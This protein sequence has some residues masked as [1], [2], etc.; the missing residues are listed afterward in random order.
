MLEILDALAEAAWDLLASAYSR[1]EFDLAYFRGLCLLAQVDFATGKPH[2]AQ[3]Q[4]ALG[5]RLAQTRGLLCKEND[6]TS[7]D[8]LSIGW[9][10]L[11]WTLFM[12]DRILTGDNIRSTCIPAF[13]F[14]LFLMR[15]GP[16]HP[17]GVAATKD[18][19]L[20]TSF[21]D[22][23]RAGSL[24]LV[25]CNILLVH[26]WDTTMQDIFQ[27]VPE[28]SVAFWRDGSSR[29]KLHSALLEF[30]MRKQTVAQSHLYSIVGSPQRVVGEPHLR[31]YFGVW[32]FF[33]IM[34]SAINC[35][36]HHPF[37]IFMKTRQHHAQVPLTY[38]QKSY[39]DS[40]I[41][42]DWVIR[43]IV[44]MQEAGI[45][46][47]DPFVGHVVAIAASI[48]LEHTINRHVKIAKVARRKFERARDFVE[49][50]SDKW[51]NM[52]DTLNVL[53]Q[54]SARLQRRQTIR[55]VQDEYNGAIPPNEIQDVAIEP[56]D[57]AL[58][59]KLFDY[60]SLS[61]E[62]KASPEVTPPAAFQDRHD[63][64]NADQAY[65]LVPNNFVTE[66]NT[67]NWPVVENRQAAA[68]QEREP[69]TD[70]FP[71]QLEGFDSAQEFTDDWSLF[72]RPWSVYFSADVV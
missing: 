71:D 27:V 61:S 68:H 34:Y 62:Q 21:E 37:I 53:E 46:L 38:L 70:L 5:L 10:S 30:E 19:T 55:H 56:E 43:H 32:V 49:S 36:L 39:Q 16:R 66:S 13:S 44:E 54:I 8:R 40:L 25:A 23:L 48:Q 18:I 67:N 31:P 20:Q 4:V 58:M 47:H 1:F 52:R 42:S 57:I 72:G 69:L 33:Q 15:N 22:K 12:M 28:T 17:D 29:A 63:M 3:A 14:H 59:W 11:V 65:N 26:L 41:H 6:R 50:M 9:R 45:P 64:V 60:A 7:N 51:P 24:D 2:R 35:C